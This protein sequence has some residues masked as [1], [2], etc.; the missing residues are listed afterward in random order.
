MFTTPTDHPLRRMFAGITEHAFH[1]TLGVAD[2]NLVDY[3]SDLLSRF[4]HVDAVFRLKD[5]SGRPMTELVEM[6]MDA[7]QLPAAGRTQ[8]EYHRHI[9]DFALYWSGLFPEQVNRMQYRQSR[10]HLI[11]FSLLGKRSYR[12]AS[13]YEERQHP[14]EARVLRQ[15]GDEFELCAVGLQEV[16]KEWDEMRKH[17]K[18]DGRIVV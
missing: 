2:P 7:E 13:T 3:V 1:N 10:D 12:L 15:L 16:R 8:C 5:N 6:A 11:S 9:G 18:G 14:A 4:L 17:P